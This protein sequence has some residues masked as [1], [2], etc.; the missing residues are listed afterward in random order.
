[1]G[2]TKMIL[3]AGCGNRTMWKTKECEKIVYM[4]IERELEV[5]PSMFGSNKYAPFK[6]E[7]FTHIFFDPPHGW[8]EGVSTHEERSLLHQHI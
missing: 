2:R 3:D 4:D 6:D 1:M 7:S 8:G 5:K